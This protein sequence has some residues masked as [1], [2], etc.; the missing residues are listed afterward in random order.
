MRNDFKSI[1]NIGIELD[2]ST[3]RCTNNIAKRLGIGR[4][5]Q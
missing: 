5:I 3:A 1:Q 4:I 2:E